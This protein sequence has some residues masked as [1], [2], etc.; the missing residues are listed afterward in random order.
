VP[1]MGICFMLAGALAL[2][3]PPSWNAWIM[4]AAFGGLHIAF[5]IP[6][7]WRHGG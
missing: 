3:T 2:F 7:A 5:G 4:A 1:V 6:V